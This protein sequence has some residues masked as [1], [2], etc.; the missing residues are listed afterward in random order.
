MLTMFYHR[1]PCGENTDEGTSVKYPGISDL[2]GYS[3]V[4]LENG[5]FSYSCYVVE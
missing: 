1:S 4:N 3:D 2:S 5:I